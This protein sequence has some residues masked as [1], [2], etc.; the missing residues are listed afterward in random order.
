MGQQVQG[1]V[2]V[3]LHP[4]PLQNAPQL[5]VH[6]FP[7]NICLQFPFLREL[8]CA[9]AAG[10]ARAPPTRTGGSG[11]GFGVRWD[12]RNRCQEGEEEKCSDEKKAEQL[13]G[14]AGRGVGRG[15]R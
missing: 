5:R 10:A 4:V 12:L 7:S 1:D 11:F 9:G 3:L 14:G 2:E 8:G 15:W 13:P 6:V